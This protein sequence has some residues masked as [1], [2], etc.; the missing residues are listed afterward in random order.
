MQPSH[1]RTPP[2]PPEA[3]RLEQVGAAGR[4]HL[5]PTSPQ[6]LA[7]QPF[8]LVSELH[9]PYEGVEPRGSAHFTQL[10]TYVGGSGMEEG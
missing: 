8:S 9:V 1:I 10:S 3:F 4:R 6:H 2:P 5:T 7:H